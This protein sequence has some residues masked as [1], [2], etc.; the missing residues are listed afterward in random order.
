LLE[1]PLVNGYGSGRHRDRSVSFL[2]ILNF[3]SI[4]ANYPPPALS[5]RHDGSIPG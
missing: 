4:Y 1:L 2:I 5:T 3:M